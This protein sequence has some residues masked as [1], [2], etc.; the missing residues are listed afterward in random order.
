MPQ[1]TPGGIA[2]YNVRD[3]NDLA[4]LVRTGM[5]WRSG[6]KVLKR[7]IDAIRAGDIARPTWNVPAAM[8]EYLDRMGVPRG[9]PR[10]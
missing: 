1:L 3:A 6:P 10:Q 5:V 7:A 2:R 9:L 4:E 8:D